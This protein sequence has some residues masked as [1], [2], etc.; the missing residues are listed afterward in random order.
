MLKWVKEVLQTMEV[1]RHKLCIK[2]PPCCFLYVEGPLSRVAEGTRIATASRE[3]HK[4]ENGR[5]HCHL[6]EQDRVMMMGLARCLGSLPPSLHLRKGNRGTVQSRF[7][8][9]CRSHGT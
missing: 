3:H 6:R 7:L 5:T 4:H 8:S 9:Q 2:C 1:S